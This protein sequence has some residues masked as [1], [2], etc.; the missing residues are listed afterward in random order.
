MAG[1]SSLLYYVALIL[2]HRPFYST[3]IHRASCR[4]AADD[5]E[6]LLLLLEKTFGFSR[7]TYLIAYCV[8]TGASVM[9]QDVKTGDLEATL[10]MESFLRALREGIKACPIVQ[11]SLE[12]ITQGLN[13]ESTAIHANNEES[14]SGEGFP[15]NYL[16]AFPTPDLSGAIELAEVDNFSGMDLEVFSFLDCFPEDNL[17]NL[18]PLPPT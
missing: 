4:K 11:R 9:I 6:I 10:K 14:V 17:D 8:Y 13:A 7:I 16:P 5:I 12:I 15:R 18:P 1:K 3:P 2:L